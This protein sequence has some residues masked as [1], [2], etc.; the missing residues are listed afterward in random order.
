MSST[1]S[2]F[3]E[4]ERMGDVVFETR[5]LSGFVLHPCS[6]PRSCY[7]YHERTVRE[8]VRERVCSRTSGFRPQLSRTNTNANANG[9]RTVR[10]RFAF[11]MSGFAQVSCILRRLAGHVVTC[12]CVGV[13]P[14]CSSMNA[15][16]CIVHMPSQPS[17][18]IGHLLICHKD[19]LGAQPARPWGPGFSPPV[20][21]HSG[22]TR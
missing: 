6:V 11:R 14:S 21:T 18:P 17:P 12:V 1:A 19:E 10:E 4:R 3:S 5:S 22:L 16:C 8:R 2:A 9:S 20:H 13:A 15:P 7:L